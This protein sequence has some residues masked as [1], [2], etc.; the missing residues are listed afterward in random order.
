MFELLGVRVMEEQYC[1]S[2]G[3]LNERMFELS[4][5]QVIECQNVN[6]AYVSRYLAFWEVF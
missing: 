2:I 1:V 4:G 5:S 3:K 6:L